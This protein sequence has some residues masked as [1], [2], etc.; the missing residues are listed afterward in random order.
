MEAVNVISEVVQEEAVCPL[1]YAPIRFDYS[2]EQIIRS[3]FRSG[4]V[5]ICLLTCFDRFC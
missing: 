1:Q 4:Y 5:L 2:A 3:G